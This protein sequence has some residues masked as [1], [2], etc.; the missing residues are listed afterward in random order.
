MGKKVNVFTLGC[1]KNRVDSEVLMKQ[2]VENGFSVD[3]ESA[4]NNHNIIIINTCGFIGDAK[5]ESIDTILSFSEA[6]EDGAIEKLIVF[7]CLSERYK[8]ELEKEIPEVDAW[9]GKFELGKML[10]YL[11]AKEF[12][13]INPSRIITTPSHYAYLKISEGCNRTC[14]YCVIP[15]ITG[16]H[17][18]RPIEEIIFEAK[19]LINQGVKEIILI[20]QDLSYYGLD[21]YKKQMLAPLMDQLA[22]LQGLKWLR[23]HYTYP[24][25]FPMDI[26]PVINKHKNICNYMDIAFQ[27]ISD[28]M[29]TKMRRNVNKADTYKLIEEFRKQVPDITLRTTLLVGHP[30]ETEQD[31]E[32]LKLFVKDIRFERLGVFPYSHEEDTF[33]YANYTDEISDEIKEQRAAEIMDIQSQISYELNEAKISKEYKVLIDRREGDY[34]IGR[35][36]FDS[37]EVDDEV[38]ITS[39]K[40]LMIG[41]YMNVKIID[42]DEYDLFA[43]P[44]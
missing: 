32:E 20:A 28:N 2:L 11:K 43:I 40:K 24:A 3:H 7:G 12:S 10:D 17:I 15:N 18:S 27:H 34:Y 39:K 25:N 6:R 19:S 14:S 29:L 8:D 5:E 41:N 35:T 37:P 13:P 4:S 26:L 1:S 16:N 44:C 33:S 30:G 36:E 22:A 23:I 42:A 38:L 21:I 9:F 31:F